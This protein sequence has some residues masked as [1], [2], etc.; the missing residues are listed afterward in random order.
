MFGFG[1]NANEP[2]Q[3]KR[4]NMLSSLSILFGMSMLIA[5]LLG[6]V[7][8]SWFRQLGWLGMGEKPTVRPVLANMLM[9]NL[10]VI[11][12]LE[13]VFRL[14]TD[15]PINEV[16]II[17]FIGTVIG[18]SLAEFHSKMKHFNEE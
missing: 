6:I 8:N 2:I 1:N 4:K 12:T 9:R 11:A 18:I 5:F 17:R 16:Y 10:L 14:A 3:I 15:A 7:V 13:C